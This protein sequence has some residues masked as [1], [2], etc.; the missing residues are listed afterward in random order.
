ME[1]ENKDQYHEQPGL[2][3]HVYWEVEDNLT[4]TMS[5]NKD[6]SPVKVNYEKKMAKTSAK[7]GRK[8]YST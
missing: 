1:N 8:K 2:I 6:T 7:K 5:M 3:Y 4:H